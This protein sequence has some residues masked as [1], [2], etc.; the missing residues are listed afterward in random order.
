MCH[1]VTWETFLNYRFERWAFVFALPLGLLLAI[2]PKAGFFVIGVMVCALVVMAIPTQRL[3][4]AA[5]VMA[6]FTFTGRLTTGNLMIPVA[7]VLAFLVA[8]SA[9]LRLGPAP[10]FAKSRPMRILIFWAGY[11]AV[12]AVFAARSSDK[13]LSNSWAI[14]RSAPNIA[15][16]VSGVYFGID[17]LVAATVAHCLRVGIVTIEG[18]LRSLRNGA[19]AAS[20]ISATFWLISTLRI[21]LPGPLAAQFPPT[22]LI[23]GF[24]R[25]AAPFLEANFLAGYL[26]VMVPILLW[27]RLTARLN[28][29]PWQL[30]ILL[31]VLFMTFSVFGFVVLIIGTVGVLLVDPES[32]RSPITL[33]GGGALM[34]V[35]IV[36]FAG[37]LRTIPAFGRLTNTSVSSSTTVQ[38]RVFLIQEAGRIWQSSPL[39]GVGPSNYG[40]AILA[41][42]TPAFNRA[43]GLGSPQVIPNNV[44]AQILAEQGIFGVVLML[45][46]LASC[47]RPRRRAI[48]SLR[49]RV[50][51]VTP[52]LL[53]WLA[54]PTLLLSY[55]WIIIGLTVAERDDKTVDNSA[56][57]NADLRLARP[58][59]LNKIRR[60]GE[61]Y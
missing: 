41:D 59:T 42:R 35:M 29:R 37:N 30:S 8:M 47:L 11:V 40:L 54:S 23:G 14:G 36:L 34:I 19:I 33:V 31:C 6:P 9:L 27:G 20:L 16:I 52:V 43:F 21:S 55:Y 10:L 17:L 46:F 7:Q 38:Q 49:S 56:K 24:V 48:L 12:L 25:T 39:V 57:A 51:L 18:L 60:R 1:L 2:R 45:L 3:V 50:V 53:A 15:P 5:T 32:R 4:Y 26:G 44:F 58:S 13:Y 28:L 22:V 61:V